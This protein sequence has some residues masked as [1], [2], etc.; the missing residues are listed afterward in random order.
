MNILFFTTNSPYQKVSPG[1]AEIS[2][3][4]IA[5]GLAQRGHNIYYLSTHR[6]YFGTKIINGIQ[7]IHYSPLRIP[8]LRFLN[9]LNSWIYPKELERKLWYYC[10]RHKIELIFTYATYPDTYCAVK[11][12]KKYKIPVVQRIAGRYW[13]VL[14]KRKPYYYKRVFD[15]F[16]NISCAIF[17]S[18]SLQRVNK[19]LLKGFS[20]RLPCMQAILDIGTNL[21][22]FNNTNSSI[23]KR[24]GADIT[25][26]FIGMFKKY[27]KRQDIL[28]KAMPY[29]L[30]KYNNIK[31]VF[32]GGGS[33]LRECKALA[34]DIGVAKHIMFL[35]KVP[36][37]EIPKIL[38]K[39]CIV[40]LA[41]EFE[42]SP[43]SIIEAMAAGKPIVASD[44]PPIKEIIKN[45]KTGLLAKNTP[46]DFAEKIVMFLNN[47]V[48]RNKLGYNAHKHA[49][50]KFDYKKCIRNY[51]I[52]LNE[53]IARNR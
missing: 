32:V 37:I 21:E 16:Q 5:E 27:S 26:T 19:E 15:T 34:Q 45:G 38:K 18:H 25:I 49:E 36:H 2:V 53:V 17:V 52:L 48:L 14:L 4:L 42:G 1:G 28:I 51:E 10:F 3:R 8:K 6:W 47:E 43:K 23:S 31:T 22:E 44:I 11:V 30:S 46:E 35:G 40:V 13:S 29:I 20:L 7:T 24:N 39:T 12:G 33:T 41:T 50:E 9:S